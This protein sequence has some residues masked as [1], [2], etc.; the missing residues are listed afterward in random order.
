MKI[1]SKKVFFPILLL[2]VL[3]CT[4]FT[5]SASTAA[6]SADENFEAPCN[7]KHVSIKIYDDHVVETHHCIVGGDMEACICGSTRDVKIP[8][9]KPVDTN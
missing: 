8:R 4:F 1:I 6:A 5:L 2:G 3:F 9:V 7:W